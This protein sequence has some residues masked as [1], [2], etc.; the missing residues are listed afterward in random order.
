MRTKRRVK[1]YL[2][3]SAVVFCFLW[4]IGAT[5]FT[6]LILPRLVMQQPQPGGLLSLDP[7]ALWLFLSIMPLLLLALAATSIAL[8]VS[9]FDEVRH[10][11][12]GN[13]A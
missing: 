10:R 9:H 13:R 8:L 7:V 1:R 5:M 11:L 4:V 12:R 6:W 3:T 2:T